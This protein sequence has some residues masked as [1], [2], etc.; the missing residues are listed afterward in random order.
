MIYFDIDGVL[1]NEKFFV[2]NG[3]WVENY[4]GKPTENKHAIELCKKLISN[5]YKVGILSKKWCHPNIDDI[6]WKKSLAQKLN[7]KTVILIGQNDNKSD[8]HSDKTDILID[9]NLKNLIAWNGIS[10]GYD[11]GYNKPVVHQNEF[12]VIDKNTSY[13]DLIQMLQKR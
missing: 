8:F 2:I 5:G 6:E 10:I 7:I 3:E 13:E 4:P 11:D 9:D 1:W 12:P